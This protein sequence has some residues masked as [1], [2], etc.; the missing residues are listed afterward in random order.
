MLRW[1]HLTAGILSVVILSSLLIVFLRR[2]CCLRRPEIEE[3]TPIRS[4]SFQARISKLHQ[5]SLIHQLDTS[6]IKRRGS[7]INQSKPGLF[8]WADHPALVTDVVEN[9]WT[10]F[11]FGSEDPHV[12]ITWEVPNGSVDF[13]QTIRFNQALRETRNP[14][15]I[16]RG[17]LPLPGPH[18]TSSAFPQEAYIEIT[19]L[20]EFCPKLVKSKEA[21][22]SLGLATLASVH[23][24]LPG[25]FP[26][27][28][29][30]QSDGSVYLDGMQLVCGSE[31]H[32]WAKENKV[33]G[34]GY[35]PS[36]KKPGKWAAHTKSLYWEF[37]VASLGRGNNGEN[38]SGRT[39]LGN[40]NRRKLDYDEE[41]DA[42]LFEIALER[43][44]RINP[45]RF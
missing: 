5:T 3:A 10:R 41:S 33:V 14:L 13:K 25:Q 34:C 40:S 42:D 1:A 4:D 17:A 45:A 8:T 7:I 2:W 15:M 38:A 21:V 18:F 39:T 9:G 11:G 29:G 28:I 32:E 24:R 12:V 35:D 31:K 37:R 20:G 36:K 44:A 22:L 6:H 19:I 30:F 43:S 26:A 27:S 23:T 16:L